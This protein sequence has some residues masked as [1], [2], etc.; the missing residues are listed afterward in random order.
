MQVIDEMTRVDALLDLL[1]KRGR[2]LLDDAAWDTVTMRKCGV[3]D[4]ERNE[5][6]KQWKYNHGLQKKII[7]ASSQTYLAGSDE[8]MP[9]G[10]AKGPR[11]D[12]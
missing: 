1:L 12:G 2:K 8:N 5:Q 9:L 10:G 11:R 7:L 3:Q 4:P 6:D